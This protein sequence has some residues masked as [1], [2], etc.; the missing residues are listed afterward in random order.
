[1]GLTNGNWEIKYQIKR[2]ERLILMNWCLKNLK[3]FKQ[4]DLNY[5]VM[6]QRGEAIVVCD[7]VGHFLGL[8]PSLT[9][10]IW[11]YFNYHRLSYYHA[12]RLYSSFLLANKVRTKA[13]NFS[14]VL[15]IGK[16]WEFIK[17]NKD[18]VFEKAPRG[19]VNRCKC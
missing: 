10:L 8:S 6:D 5:D 18:E 2:F 17:E 3:R 13:F 4:G 14:V 19:G 16:N 7:N 15:I 11:A 9:Y 12:I 1:M